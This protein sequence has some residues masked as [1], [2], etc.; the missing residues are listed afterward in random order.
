[1]S[2][3]VFFKICEN[4]ARRDGCDLA[5]HW[6]F[7]GV[8]LLDRCDFKEVDASKRFEEFPW[9]DEVMKFGVEVYV[10]GKTVF[11]H[12]PM[13]PTILA[14]SAIKVTEVE[15]NLFEIQANVVVREGDE[16]K[17]ERLVCRNIYVYVLDRQHNLVIFSTGVYGIKK[18]QNVL[19]TI[20]ELSI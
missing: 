5:L 2:K 6:W 9:L 18:L 12:K 16:S 14:H 11:I 4:C 1:M 7:E 15:E 19:S 17:I 10:D 8:R 20:L 3:E 13:Q